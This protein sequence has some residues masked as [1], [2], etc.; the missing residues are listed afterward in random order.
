MEVKVL[1]RSKVRLEFQLESFLCNGN[2]CN[3]KH[4]EIY[5]GIIRYTNIQHICTANIANVIFLRDVFL[6]FGNY[7]KFPSTS[8]RVDRSLAMELPDMFLF[9][10]CAPNYFPGRTSHTRKLKV[11]LGIFA[12]GDKAEVGGSLV[13]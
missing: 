8:L 7:S 11:N 5:A 3:R 4:L 2:L 9:R 6:I 12:R 10:D 13:A 1:L